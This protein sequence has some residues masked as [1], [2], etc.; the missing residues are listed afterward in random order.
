[1]AVLTR[2]TRGGFSLFELLVL[3]AI[4]AFLFALLFPAVFKVRQ[5]AARAN[6][7]NN[8]KQLGLAIHNMNDTYAQLPPVVG[9]YPAKND[10]SYGSLFFYMLPFIEQDNVYKN[11]MGEADGKNGYYVWINNTAS[12][13]IKV[14]T[15][16]DDKSNP[17]NQLFHGWLATSSYAANAM[18]FGR[19]N[20]SG[21][22]LSLQGQGRFPASIPDGLSNTLM[23]AERYQR[24]GEDACAWG[25]YGDYYWLPAFAYY[26]IGKFQTAP[27]A[28]V[29]DSAL[30]QTPHSSGIQ[31]CF[32]DGSVRNLAPAL[33]PRT[34]YLLCH[35]A[36]GNP[37][38]P[39]A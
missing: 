24:C 5:A 9:Q 7:T 17:A 29:C 28:N 26:S 12:V 35:P 34:W 3:I 25:Y 36:D 13:V 8:L 27:A 15:C 11:A 32:A 30:A 21:E 20:A 23:F 37:I 6:C 38:P 1:M 4:L 18:A 33:S 2:K 22:I 31:V 39:D 16:P 19:I 10:A 14:F